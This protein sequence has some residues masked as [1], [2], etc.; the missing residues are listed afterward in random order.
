MSGLDKDRFRNKTISF[1][2]SPEERRLLEAKIKISGLQKGEYFREMLLRSHIS[3]RVGKFES[4]R[5][6]LELKEIRNNLNGYVLE[7]NAIEVREVV[8][9]C[10]E[11][12]NELL[13]VTRNEQ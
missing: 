5:L 4:D 10:L 2:M 6:S 11:I 7:D 8:L 12:L 13:K 1:R 3:I 9:D